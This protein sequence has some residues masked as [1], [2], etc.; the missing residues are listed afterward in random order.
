MCTSPTPLNFPLDFITEVL[1]R[2]DVPTVL[3]MRWRGSANLGDVTAI[4]LSGQLGFNVERGRAVS[5]GLCRDRAGRNR[6]ERSQGSESSAGRTGT[7]RTKVRLITCD[8]VPK[9]VCAPASERLALALRSEG[10]SDS[11]KVSSQDQRSGK[12]LKCAGVG[13]GDSESTRRGGG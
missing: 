1:P 12:E 2:W 3:H 5:G 6:R 7:N 11:G 4:H 13:A 8:W 9:G 10:N